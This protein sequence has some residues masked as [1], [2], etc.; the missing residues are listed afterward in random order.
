MNPIYVRFE[1]S[2][3]IEAKKLILSSKAGLISMQKRL[4]SYKITRHTILAKK[5]QLKKS[6]RELAASIDITLSALPK[7]EKKYLDKEIK[8]SDISKKSDK[9]AMSFEQELSDIQKQLA[10]LNHNYR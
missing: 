9:K 2:E 4:H 10:A 7:I 5:L 1:H 8:I 6:L 3:S